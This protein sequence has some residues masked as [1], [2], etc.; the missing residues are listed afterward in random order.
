MEVSLLKHGGKS[1][2]NGHQTNLWGVA[3]RTDFDPDG[4]CQGM[5]V[6]LLISH[7]DV[8]GVTCTVPVVENGYQMSR[9]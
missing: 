8:A 7:A 5:I 4:G 6:F 2:K 1:I 9:Y 3:C